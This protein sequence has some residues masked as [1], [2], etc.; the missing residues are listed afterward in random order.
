[1]YVV[2]LCLTHTHTR[3][4]Q[5]PPSRIYT[6]KQTHTQSE[7]TLSVAVAVAIAIADILVVKAVAVPGEPALCA[8]QQ[9]VQADG[10]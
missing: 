9:Q 5:S 3:N 10:Q 1:M 7:L 8:G 2:D 6:N 4:L